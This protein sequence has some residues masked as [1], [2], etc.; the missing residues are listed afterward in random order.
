METPFIDWTAKVPELAML[1]VGVPF[2][3]APHG[4]PGA[5]PG[6]PNRKSWNVWNVRAPI[7]SL[8]EGAV[9]THIVD[10][11]ARSNSMFTMV[12][13][14]LVARSQSSY[15]FRRPE[16]EIRACAKKSVDGDLIEIVDRW[17]NRCD[18]DL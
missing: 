15:S 4:P 18:A 11:E 10:F 6:S 16:I 13:G 2:V 12:P 9:R 1:L 17:I 7:W 8:G 5:Q 14:N 3:P